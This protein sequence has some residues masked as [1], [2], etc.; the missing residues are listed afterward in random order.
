MTRRPV[1]RFAGF[2][3]GQVPM[4]TLPALVFVELLPHLAD[5]DE[6]KVVLHVLWR[7]AS[8][9]SDGAP[10]ITEREL[11]GDPVLRIAIEGQA[12]VPRLQAALAKAVDHGILLAAPWEDAEGV[13]EVRY[14][15]NSPQGRTSVA[16]LARGVSPARATVEERPNIFAL[17][18]QTIGPLTALLSEE[19][20]DAERTYPAEWIEDA[21]RE[22]A[23]LNKRNWKYVLAILER[24]QSEGRGGSDTHGIDREADR[25]AGRRDREAETRRYLEDAY[26]RL[27]KH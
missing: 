13:V 14:F 12:Q 26:D 4:V 9:R 11:L 17:Y 7:L 18:E 27:I 10:W 6:V 8:M 2:P 19:L 24:W 22:A 3:E 25:E 1:Y 5:L 15:A 23:R 16:A 20:M 21:F